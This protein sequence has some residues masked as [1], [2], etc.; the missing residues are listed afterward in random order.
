MH[1]KH[2]LLFSNSVNKK[3]FYFVF[4]SLPASGRHNI[5]NV[6]QHIAANL[7]HAHINLH[8]G[9]PLGSGG[10]ASRHPRQPSHSATIYQPKRDKR[11]KGRERKKR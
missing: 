2:A 6:V 10:Q 8:D 1:Q 11:E 9:S 4:S 3:V 7:I 5:I